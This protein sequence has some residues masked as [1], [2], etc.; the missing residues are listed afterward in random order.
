MQLSLNDSPGYRSS[1]CDLEA[2]VIKLSLLGDAV[3]CT[4]MRHLNSSVNS[5]QGFTEISKKDG[6]QQAR[7][8]DAGEISP[9]KRSPLKGAGVSARQN[10]L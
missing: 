5:F 9:V 1:G 7:G 2:A 4:R 8:D 10:I 3:C 6:K